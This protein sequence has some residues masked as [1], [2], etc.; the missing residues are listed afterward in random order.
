[1][2]PPYLLDLRIAESGKRPL[3]LWLPLF[4]LWPLG[5]VLLVLAF[6]IAIPLDVMLFVFGQRYHRYT[7]LLLGCLEML[8]QT[9]GLTAY[10]CG[11]NATVD[12][13]VR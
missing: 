8:S 5:L 2:M 11:D 9:R 1:M 10:V 13:T 12:M 7:L 6:A 3:R 4:L